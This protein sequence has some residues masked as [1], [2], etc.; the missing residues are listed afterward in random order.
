MEEQSNFNTPLKTSKNKDFR[1]QEYFC[2][3]S[4]LLQY[5][6]VVRRK[7]FCAKVLTTQF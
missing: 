2:V 1:N 3:L 6:N 7:T 5:L 4:I